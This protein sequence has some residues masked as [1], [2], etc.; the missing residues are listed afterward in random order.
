MT[1]VRC[2]KWISKCADA[3]VCFL[4]A[5]WSKLNYWGL[6]SAIFAGATGFIG[7]KH[8]IPVREA[9]CLYIKK[10]TGVQLCVCEKNSLEN[11]IGF[12]HTQSSVL[13]ICVK[14]LK[15]ITVWCAL[16]IFQTRYVSKIAKLHWSGGTVFLSFVISIE[17]P[18]TFGRNAPIWAFSDI[19]LVFKVFLKRV[20]FRRFKPK[21]AAF[22]TFFYSKMH[23]QLDSLCFVLDPL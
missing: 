7:A 3:W 2:L 6:W 11:I 18:S 4:L 21:T 16:W 20:R 17:S 9:F 15:G 12:N 10:T 8:H 19:F 5:C 22:S 1:A 13:E 23:H 14:K